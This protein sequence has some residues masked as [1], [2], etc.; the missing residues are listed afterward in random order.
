M[1]SELSKNELQN[2]GI[3][4]PKIAR[5]VLQK[6]IFVDYS[7]YHVAIV[8]AHHYELALEVFEI[9]KLT[10]SMLLTKQTRVIEYAIFRA[11]LFFTFVILHVVF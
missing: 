8:A 9:V 5:I 11:L 10:K 3:R 1:G 7:G 4:H 6:P 2:L